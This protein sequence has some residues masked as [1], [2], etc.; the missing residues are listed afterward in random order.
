MDF[1]TLL[2]KISYIEAELTIIKK[3]LVKQV[4]KE[5]KERRKNKNEDS[6]S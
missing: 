6:K 2:K 1:E 5:K 4:R 3:E